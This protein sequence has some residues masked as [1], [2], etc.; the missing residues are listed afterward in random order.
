MLARLGDTLSKDVAGFFKGPAD[1]TTPAD[2][3]RPGFLVDY[4]ATHPSTRVSPDGRTQVSVPVLW[5]ALIEGLAPVWPT[6]GRTVL[7]GT[8]MGDVWPCPALA[9]SRGVKLGEQESLVPFHKL[10]QWLCYSIMEPMEK[11]LGWEFVDGDAQTV[12]GC[13]LCV[14]QA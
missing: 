9:K 5:A 11:T 10:S 3:R 13:V 1:T 12:N 2:R 7:D 4:L 6:E 8:V 14:L